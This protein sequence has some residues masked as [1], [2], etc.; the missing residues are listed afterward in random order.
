MLDIS[1]ERLNYE[2]ID[3]YIA[4][5][6]EFQISYK[7]KIKKELIE[8][9]GEVY[10]VE[11]EEEIAQACTFLIKTVL[12]SQGSVDAETSDVKVTRIPPRE[13]N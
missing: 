6:M 5:K 10:G 13:L 9:L 2:L 12:L 11:T 3:R 8:E 1:I 4:K 7:I